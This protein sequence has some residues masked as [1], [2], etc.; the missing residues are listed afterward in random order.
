MAVYKDLYIVRHG[1]STRDYGD[2]SDIDRPLKERGINDSYTMAQRFLINGKI[3]D[4]IISSPAIRALHSATIFARTFNLPYNKIFIDEVI[5]MAG[6]K[7]MIDFIKKTENDV[8]SLMIFGHNP[9]FT[10]LANFFLDKNIG[11]LPTTGIVGIR[12]RINK[13][14]EID[15]I[16]PIESFF[17]FPKNIH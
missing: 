15:R 8:K 1:K 11:N 5:Y 17:D 7:F 2:I 13:W 16:K 14:S 4:K 10:H 3:P 6:T 9:T 12:F